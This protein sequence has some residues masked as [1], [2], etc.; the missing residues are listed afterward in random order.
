MPAICSPHKLL[1]N[2]VTGA[3]NDRNILVA[4]DGSD[5]GDLGL[6]ESIKLAKSLGSRIRLIHVMNEADAVPADFPGGHIADLLQEARRR[7]EK[8][9]APVPWMLEAA[10]LL[11][12]TLHEYAEAAVIGVLLVFSAMLGFVQEGRV[13]ATLTAKQLVASLAPIV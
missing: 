12:F 6:E 10:T 4:I 1:Y 13:Q 7:G 9:W 5:T 2:A 11:Q 8:L 3:S